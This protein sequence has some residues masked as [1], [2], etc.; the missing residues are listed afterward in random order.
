MD[1]VA[2][3]IVRHSKKIIALTIIINLIALASLIRAR[4]DVSVESFFNLGDKYTQALNRITKKYGGTDIVQVVI[5]SK[6]SLLTEKNI[7]AIWKYQK[8]ITSI[9]G[10]VSA[11]SFIPQTIPATYPPLKTNENALKKYYER[12]AKIVSQGGGLL[13]LFI[14]RDKK[15]A[16]VQV[17]LRENEDKY[18]ILR[19]IKSTPKP[20]GMDAR[21]T[22]TVV[23]YDTLW[24][25]LLKILLVLPPAV[26]IIL[27]TI[28]YLN[29]RDRKHTLFALLP[30][31]FGALWVFGTIFWLGIPLNLILIV[32]PIFVI[33]MGSAD[34]LHFV[35]HYLENINTLKNTLK[36]D[37]NGKPRATR[38]LKTPDSPRISEPSQISE[39]LRVPE[40]SHVSENLQTPKHPHAKES[41]KHKE[42]I[43]LTKA[44]REKTLKEKAIA[45][46][47]QEVGIPMILTSLTTMLGFISLAVSKILALKYLGIFTAIGIAYAGIVSW[48]FLPA[49]LSLTTPR[50]K[51]ERK[52]LGEHILVWLDWLIKHPVLPVSF[53]LLIVILSAIAI[54]RLKVYSDQLLFFKKHSR[55][56]KDFAY[57]EKKFG[58]SQPVVG[59][60]KLNAELWNRGEMQ[61]IYNIERNMEKIKGIYRVYSIIDALKWS[62]EIQ[63][64]KEG[65]PPPLLVRLML[66]MFPQSKNMVKDKG[67][68]IFIITKDWNNESADKLMQYASKHKNLT[69]TGIPILFAR[70][71]ELVVETQKKSFVITFIGIFFMLLLLYRNLKYALVSMIPISITVTGIYGLLYITQFNLNLLTVTMSSIAIGV[72]IDYAIHFVYLI[73]FYKKRGY[74]SYVEEAM[75]SSGIPI[76]AN[77]LGISTGMIA[78]FLSPL[79][80]HFQVGVVMIFAM[81][82]SS[83]STLTIIPLFFKA[84]KG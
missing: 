17:R 46:T 4:I 53:F 16:I 64:K 82:V 50:V 54:P 62:Y 30:A 51:F 77:A 14:S 59:E 63:V 41:L 69:I 5:S 28:F 31:G 78:M 40:N 11:I 81:L 47:L 24:H 25:V 79:R 8:Q 34:G 33:I 68:L 73:D 80:I 36:P 67:L 45:K 10:V 35:I 57:V 74:K 75:K 23:I 38:N 13:P 29:V 70:L 32:T 9:K 18:K 39:N 60:I 76:L 15:T 55:I 48:F 52:K 58:S 12:V 83:V 66:K 3:F 7:L 26:I 71:N 84:K 42:K 20:N 72:G 22:G 2:G 27:L 21:Y 19:E 49:I 43:V 1:K 37:I 6:A 56:R 44:L 65:F 61:R